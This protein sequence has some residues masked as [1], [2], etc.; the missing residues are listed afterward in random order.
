MVEYKK[1]NYIRIQLL[2]TYA[3]KMNIFPFSRQKE[4]ENLQQVTRTVFYVTLKT[5]I[6]VLK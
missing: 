4:R 2:P 5:K 3:I 1:I 6:Y